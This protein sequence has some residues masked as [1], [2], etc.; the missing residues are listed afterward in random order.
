MIMNNIR[1]LLVAA[2]FMVLPTVAVAQTQDSITL[3]VD[4]NLVPIEKPAY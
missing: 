3:V 4:E 1:N 2:T